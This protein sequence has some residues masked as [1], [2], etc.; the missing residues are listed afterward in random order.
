MKVWYHS[1]WNNIRITDAKRNSY[2]TWEDNQWL[3]PILGGHVE[4]YHAVIGY[5]C[6][7]DL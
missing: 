7:G 2:L 4:D 3:P 6:L 5:V 1:Y